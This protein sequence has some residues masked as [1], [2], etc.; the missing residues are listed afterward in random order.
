V[1]TDPKIQ[2]AKLFR[3]HCAACHS[4]APEGNTSDAS[5]AIVTEKPTAANLWNFGSR[6]WVRGI[7]DPEEIAGPHYYGNTAFKEGDMVAWVKDNIGA[8]LAD[9]KGDELAEYRNK[10]EN[11]AFALAGEAGLIRELA[12]DIPGRVAAGR[13]AMINTFACIDCHKFH[14]DGELGLA[15]DL[16]GYASREWLTAFLS[17]PAAERFYGDRNDRMPA[18]AAHPENQATNRLTAAE[19]D[20]LVSWLRG[21]WY[22]P[23]APQEGAMLSPR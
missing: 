21:E 15:P 11:I 1:R 14:D 3:Q 2:G 17:N 16:T 7:L 22:E 4:H 19:I 13:D 23:G 6:D 12:A 5:Q 9:L 20:L 18:F 10:I 8:Q